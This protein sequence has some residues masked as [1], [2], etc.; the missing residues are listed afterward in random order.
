MRAFIVMG[1]ESTG[2]RV[3]TQILISAGCVGDGG[4]K[5]RFDEHIPSPEEVGSDIV[6]RRSVPHFNAED[7]PTIKSMESRLEGYDVKILI[8]S[9]SLYPAAKSQ[10]NHRDHLSSLEQAYDRINEGYSYIFGQISEYD[11]TVVTY[12]GLRRN[13]SKICEQIGI[14]EPDVDIYDGNEKYYA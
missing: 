4:H 6:W 14:G 9:R 3:L 13:D 10:M 5:Q 1:P 7:M 12:E 8:T 2:T 11:F